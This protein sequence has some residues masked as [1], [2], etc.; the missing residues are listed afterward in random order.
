MTSP[1]LAEA[2]AEAVKSAPPIAVLGVTANGLTLE[3][4]VFIATLVYLALQTGWLL[5]R[6]WRAASTKGWR[7]ND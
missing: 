3:D 2:G 4:W 1:K 5:W 7:P 6:W